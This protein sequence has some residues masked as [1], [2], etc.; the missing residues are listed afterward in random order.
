MEIHFHS[1]GETLDQKLCEDIYAL[2]KIIRSQSRIDVHRINGWYELLRWS[3]SPEIKSEHFTVLIVSEN[4]Y[5]FL[6]LVI[7][8]SRIK[9]IKDAECATSITTRMIDFVLANEE[10]QT[11]TLRPKPYNVTLSETEAQVICDMFLSPQQLG[12]SKGNIKHR[13][14]NKMGLNNNIEMFIWWNLTQNLPKEIM[15]NN[16][17]INME[18]LYGTTPFT[19]RQ[20]FL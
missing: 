14:K 3:S 2:R 12:K 19:A 16:I 11:R 6:R 13:I 10:L 18:Y 15:N 9:V 1:S 5:S 20:I 8:G 7:R 4:I 17:L